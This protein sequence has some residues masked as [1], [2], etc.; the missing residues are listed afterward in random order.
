MYSGSLLTLLL[1]AQIECKKLDI[2]KSSIFSFL[3]FMKRIVYAIQQQQKTTLK[4]TFLKP[5]AV[6]AFSPVEFTPL[7]SIKVV[8]INRK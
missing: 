5:F 8:H 1:N 3:P 4:H 2:D 7:P 6:S